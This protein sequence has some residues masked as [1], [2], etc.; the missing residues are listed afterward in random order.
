[1]EQIVTINCSARRQKEDQAVM[2]PMLG[3]NSAE[4]RMF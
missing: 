1:M 4:T 2:N 3:E